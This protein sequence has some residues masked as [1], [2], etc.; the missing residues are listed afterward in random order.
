MQLKSARTGECLAARNT[1]Y[2]IN[3]HFH[4]VICKADERREYGFLNILNTVAFIISYLSSAL[5]QSTFKICFSPCYNNQAAVQMHHSE[6]QREI[7]KKSLLWNHK[8]SDI[9]VLANSKRDRLKNLSSLSFALQAGWK[10]QG[11]AHEAAQEAGQIK[12]QNALWRLTVGPESWFWILHECT[13]VM[14]SADNH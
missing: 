7:K 1:F 2:I 9:S 11:D 14:H 12:R 3:R 13:G 8:T 10:L 5:F 4:S 6:A